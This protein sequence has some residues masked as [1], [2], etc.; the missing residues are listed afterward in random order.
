MITLITSHL[1]KID[2]P[3]ALIGDNG[4]LHKYLD[5]L[6]F[7]VT[8][9]TITFF[10]NNSCDH[11]QNTGISYSPRHWRAL[12][13]DIYH[14]PFIIPCYLVPTHYIVYNIMKKNRIQSN[15]AGVTLSRVL[16]YCATCFLGRTYVCSRKRQ[17]NAVKLYHQIVMC[18]Y[19]RSAT[20][21]IHLIQY[22]AIRSRYV[23]TR[24]HEWKWL[25]T[26]HFIQT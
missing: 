5:I 9:S 25:G 8:S 24:P 23:P 15:F 17:Y 16:R 7:R 20:K 3:L 26:F 18:V 22:V 2:K 21:K 19:V 14:R 4:V 13:I 11:A 12:K 6:L 10:I 1:P